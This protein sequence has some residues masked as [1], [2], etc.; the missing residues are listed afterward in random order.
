MEFKYTDRQK[1]YL[2]IFCFTFFKYK[3]FWL[4]LGK[5]SASFF[6][7]VCEWCWIYI[8]QA[9]Q[10]LEFHVV[11]IKFWLFIFYLLSVWDQKTKTFQNQFL[12]S[13]NWIPLGVCLFPINEIFICFSAAKGSPAGSLAICCI[14]KTAP[15]SGFFLLRRADSANACE[16]L[17]AFVQ[18]HP[19]EQLGENEKI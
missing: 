16:C 8:S 4:N 6:L 2:E 14:F 11:N 9:D 13:I 7:W 3:I 1:I 15:S 12:F 10:K 17:I 5:W 19:D 18:Q